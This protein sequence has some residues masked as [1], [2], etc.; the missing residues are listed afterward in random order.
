MS[1]RP[2]A[3]GLTESVLARLR[4]LARKQDRPFA[5][6]FQLYGL[7]R[8]LYRLSRTAQADRTA[9]VRK[10]RLEDRTLPLSDTVAKV[11]DFLMPVLSAV[12]RG[13]LFQVR[14]TAGGPWQSR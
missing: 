5:E 4:N 9:F 3:R 14:W 11:R 8:Y 12:A 2:R 6:V 7:E 13:E 1:S 10:N